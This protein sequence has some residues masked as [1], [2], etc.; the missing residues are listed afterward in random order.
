MIKEDQHP[1]CLFDEELGGRFKKK[2]T[3]LEWVTWIG[4]ER[5]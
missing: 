3:L 5:C 4:L 2:L 1:G